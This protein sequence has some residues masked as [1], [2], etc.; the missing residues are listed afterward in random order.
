MSRNPNEPPSDT[1]GESSDVPSINNDR[2]S[3]ETPTLAYTANGN[4]EAHS[5]V[6]W[7]QSHGVRAYAVE[8]NSGVSLF[9]FGTISQFHKPQVFVDKTDLK[10]AVDLLR[11]FETQ[12]DRR[13]KDLDNLPPIES[14]CEECGVSSEFPASQDGTTQNCPKC[15]AFMDVGGHDWPEDFD[16]GEVDAPTPSELTADDA[17]DAASRLDKL[18]DWLDAIHAFRDIASQWPEHA[19]YAANCIS[20]IQ[21][22][23]D[24][25]NG[26]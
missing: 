20:A 26:G 16:F 13:R 6:T 2:D 9:A 21:R 24:A 11:E 8:D 23:I 17:I 14:E 5:V 7:L 19:T 18:G 1:S 3:L 4:L 22:K 10:S 15:N 25:A 12:R